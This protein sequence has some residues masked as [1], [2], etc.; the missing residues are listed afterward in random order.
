MDLRLVASCRGQTTTPSE[1]E[2]FLD[3]PAAEHEQQNNAQ[4]GFIPHYIN[5][6]QQQKERVISLVLF[7]EA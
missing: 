4:I 6:Q 7:R 2:L 3:K 1:R 5:K